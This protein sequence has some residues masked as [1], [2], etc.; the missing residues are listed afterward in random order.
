LNR[1][2]VSDPTAAAI[3]IVDT[4]VAAVMSAELDAVVRPSAVA[5]RSW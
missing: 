2:I 4:G 1:E 3:S 5:H